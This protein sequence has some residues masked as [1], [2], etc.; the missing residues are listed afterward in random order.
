MTKNSLINK[1]YDH[2]KTVIDDIFQEL[3]HLTL[4]VKN[5]KL[6]STVDN[7]RARL[8]E[9]FLFVIVGEVKVGKSSFIN[10]LLATGKEVTK[11]APDPCTDT[12]QQIVYSETESV[13]PINDYLKKITVPAEILKDIAIVDTPGTNTIIDHHQEITEKFIPVSDLIIFVFE[14]KN[15]YRQSA[16]ELL[17]YVN[18][19]WRKKV[20]FV[21]Q[22][23]D[24]IEP[25]NLEINLRGV[26]QQASKKGISDPKVFAVSAKRELDGDTENSGFDAI[27]DFVNTTVTGGNNVRLKVE[28]LL[29][30]SKNI[31]GT[32][33]TGLDARTKQLDTDRDFRNR[34]NSLL[35]SS[36]QKSSKQVDS[37]VDDLLREYDKITSD[38]QRDFEGGLGVFT[39]VK[40]SFLS[41]FSSGQTL[42]DWLETITARFQ[43][44]LKPALDKKLRTGVKNMA[45]SIKQMAEIIDVEI[46]KNKENLQANA[47]L[48]GDIANKRQEK[49][50]NLQANV[51]DFISET[52]N[53]INKDMLEKGS[54][55]IPNMATGGGLMVVGGILMSV[56]SAIAVDVTGGI[57]TALGLG[58]ASIYTMS[59]RNSIVNEFEEE[60]EKGRQKLKEEV[61]DRL[62]DY[63]KEIRTKV[64]NNFLDFDAYIGDER[65]NLDSFIDQYQ[66]IHTKFEKLK[67]DFEIG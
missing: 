49:L 23:S 17:D 40:K 19:K 26:T 21:L 47:Q 48:F 42:E 2:Y 57:L 61:M 14:A 59:Q 1:H 22:Q 67:K 34:V 53:F 36:E 54:A 62:S 30:T 15:P 64:D 9:P 37:I 3:H 25:E 4:N 52:E 32:I 35:D 50:E 6:S 28:S 18:T 46:R 66:H 38:I 33:Q 8:N 20:I 31:M 24:L 43:K 7:I 27:R 58:I 16:W 51:E 65:K 41:I 5:E 63:V 12:I 13:I 45:E 11:V 55:L 44:D 29:S 60:I 39:L 56:T 10:A